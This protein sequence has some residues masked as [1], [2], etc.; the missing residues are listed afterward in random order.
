MPARLWPLLNLV[1]AP[2][3][4]TAL[5]DSVAGFALA[6]ATM[7]GATFQPTDLAL[8]CSVS[9]LSYWF[10]MATNDVLDRHKDRRS[11]PERPLA[12]GTLSVLHAVILCVALLATATILAAAAEIL[13]VSLALVAVIMA[14]NGGGK[15]IPVAGN[16]LMG[17]CRSLNLLVGA[18]AVD[19]VPARS[20][21]TSPVLLW[22]AGVLGVYIALVTAISVLEDRPYRRTPLTLLCGLLVCFP[23]GLGVV[24]PSHPGAWVNAILFIAL[25]A[26]AYRLPA[27]SSVTP[28]SPHP[29]KAVVRQGLAGLYFIDAGLLWWYGL[30]VAAATVYGLFVLGWL[31]RRWWVQSTAHS[32]GHIQSG[33]DVP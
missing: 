32:N 31:W 33:R 23:V 1:R 6:L 7:T 3:T 26:R 10:G 25:V 27:E 11:T 30:E 8:A 24:G 28:N 17:S 13:V 21:F 18:A 29:A 16:L 19:G 12:R 15:R 22:A 9:V 14:Y 20:V 4:P 5:A 2:L